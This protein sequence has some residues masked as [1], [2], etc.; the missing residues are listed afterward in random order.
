[1]TNPNDCGEWRVNLRREG[2]MIKNLARW[3]LPAGMQTL[4]HKKLRTHID[5]HKGVTKTYLANIERYRFA[6]NLATSGSVLDAACG[7]GHGSYYLR[8]CAYTGIDVRPEVIDEAFAEFG[9]YGVFRCCDVM[10]IGGLFDAIVSFDTLEHV[11]YD[12]AALTRFRECL[13]P[14]GRLIISLPIN[15][16]DTV[17]HKAV[18]KSVKECR[19]LVAGV[20]SGHLFHEFVQVDILIDVVSDIAK[21]EWICVVEG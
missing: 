12:R 20:F 19:S 21:G 13:E 18:Y 8:H 11:E 14:G 15:H 9:K 16:P 5:V 7:A 4:L 2:R 17:H 3:L 1:M 10:D 6:A